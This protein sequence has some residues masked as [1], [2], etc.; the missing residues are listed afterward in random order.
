MF[1]EVVS[2]SSQKLR[3][4]V[5]IGGTKIQTVA[6]N[7]T[8]VVGQNRVSTP[9]EG[10]A[11]VCDAIAASVKASLNAVGLD[12][13][14]LAAVGMGCP[15]TIDT[16]EGTVEH[17]PNVHGFESDQPI[18]LA[19]E[20]SGRLGNA[21]VR[22]DNDVRVAVLG[23]WKHGAGKG[24]R[25]F[26]GV[27]LGTGVG[28]GL[29]LGNRL[30]EG[31][32]AA[33]EIGH[34]TVHPSGRRCGCGRKGCLEAYAGRGSLQRRI[35]RMARQGEKSIVLKLMKDRGT[36]VMLSSMFEKALKKRDRVVSNL[37]SDLIDALAIALANTQNLLDLD[38]FI[39]GGGLGGRLGEQLVADVTEK[40]TPRLHVP[41]RPPAVKLAALE[42]LSGAVGAAELVK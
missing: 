32:G 40:M 27:F 31:H 23:E 15:G 29:V 38:T 10:V 4:G 13:S 34:M 14:S 28:G 7:G 30:Y 33:G 16:A 22:L 25:D 24:Q 11:S 17:S 3:A 18:P 19:S 2:N 26:M 39:L 36:T 20:V 41:E 12:L 5:D 42:D 1:N 21:R 6:M 8:R 37:Y 35:E 9:R